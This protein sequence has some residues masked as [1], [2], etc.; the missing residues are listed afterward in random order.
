MYLQYFTAVGGESP[1]LLGYGPVL[2]NSGVEYEETS[3]W[4]LDEPCG[5]MLTEGLA[6]TPASSSTKEAR[7]W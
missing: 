5:W 7:N 4:N 6:F 1:E 2:P 3:V